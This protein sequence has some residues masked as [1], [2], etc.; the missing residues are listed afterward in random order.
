[1]RGTRKP[2]APSPS[3]GSILAQVENEKGIA[4]STLIKD[5]ESAII[6]AAQRAFGPYRQLEAQFNEDTGEIELYQEL[7]VVTVVND[8]DREISLEAVEK[9][10]DFG[11]V[12]AG[13]QLLFQ[14]FWRP[15]EAE[16]ARAQERA[17]GHLMSRIRD[18]DR[19]IIHEEYERRKAEL[20][21]P[22]EKPSRKR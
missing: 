1:M 18:E 13:E 21:P 22:P 2:P 5:F 10:G 15:E 4:R 14:I 12:E 11:D 7:N 19:A 9:H 16:A 6:A 8:S 3:L 20:M 17:F